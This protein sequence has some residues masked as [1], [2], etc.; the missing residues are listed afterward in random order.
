MFSRIVS[1]LNVN[2]ITSNP[3]NTFPIR[4]QRIPDF[5][6]RHLTLLKFPIIIIY[7][8][9]ITICNIPFRISHIL[10]NNLFYPINLLYQ[11]KFISQS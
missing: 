1:S 5:T 6:I 3:C 11:R 4:I 7:Y 10:T 8:L 2:F 9:A